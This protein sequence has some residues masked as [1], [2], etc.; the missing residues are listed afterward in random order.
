MITTDQEYHQSR[1]KLASLAGLVASTEAGR[2]GDHAFR[3]LQ[4]AGLRGFA[5]DLRAE[6]AAYETRRKR[7]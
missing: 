1:E 3:D 7:S 5:G 6:I 4:L 2:A